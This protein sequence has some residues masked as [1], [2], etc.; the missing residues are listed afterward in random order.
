MPDTLYPRLHLRSAP[1]PPSLALRSAGC[2]EICNRHAFSGNHARPVRA[3]VLERIGRGDTLVVVYID[4]RSRSI[5]HLLEAIKRQVLDAGICSEL[6]VKERLALFSGHS[7]RAGLASSAEVDER[8]VQK[9]LA[10][11]RSR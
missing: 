6:P 9:Q 3:R 1:L 7:L 5:S 8:Y 11:P 10:M 4:R 2:A